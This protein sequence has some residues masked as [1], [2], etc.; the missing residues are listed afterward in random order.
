MTVQMILDSYKS[1]AKCPNESTFLHV[2]Q[3]LDGCQ[4]FGACMTSN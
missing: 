2:S 4:E 3:D 1:T